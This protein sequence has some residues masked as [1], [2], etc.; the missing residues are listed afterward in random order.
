MGAHAVQPGVVDAVDRVNQGRKEQR[1]SAGDA[2][3]DHAQSVDE[4]E[5]LRHGVAGNFPET[6]EGLRGGGAIS[7]GEPHPDIENGFRRGRPVDEDSS[8]LRIHAPHRA[9]ARA[10]FGIDAGGE[11]VAQ[12]PG[13]R[14]DGVVADEELA[15][16][17]DAA[18][19]TRA[20]GEA[21]Q[22]L[23]PLGAASLLEQAVDIGEKAGDGF[24]VD[25][26]VAII[27]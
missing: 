25:E 8:A 13:F 27:S 26:Q 1:I 15:V 6:A 20:Q 21:E 19:Q 22:V 14:G 17:R 7:F 2:T 18:A 11:L 5:G 16:A 12:Q 10:F 24:T 3:A 23:V 9:D 4:G